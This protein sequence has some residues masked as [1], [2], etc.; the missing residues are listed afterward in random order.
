[1]WT[2][3]DHI[4]KNA[5]GNLMSSQVPDWD[6]FRNILLTEE[7]MPDLDELGEEDMGNALHGLEFTGSLPAWALFE[8]RLDELNGNMDGEFDQSIGE[9]LEQIPATSWGSGAWDQ[10]SARLDDLNAEMD[11]EFDQTIEDAMVNIPEASWKEQH[12]QMLSTRLDRLNDKPR[13]LMMKVIEAAAILLLLIQLSNL[14]TGYQQNKGTNNNLTT[15]LDRILDSADRPASEDNND[16]VVPP[17]SLPSES[18]GNINENSSGDLDPGRSDIKSSINSDRYEGSL[19][20]ESPSTHVDRSS[21]NQGGRTAGNPGDERISEP[22]DISVVNQLPP[23]QPVHIPYD[24]IQELVDQPDV[25]PNAQKDNSRVAPHLASDPQLIDYTLDPSEFQKSSPKLG[26]RDISLLSTSS[27]DSILRTIPTL[28]VIRPRIHSSMEVGMLADATN[29]EIEDYYS[30]S[31]AYD[32]RTLNAGGYFRYKIQYQNIFGSLGADYLNMRY[33]GVTSDNKLSMI[34]L[35][36]E[37]GYNVV[38]LP[39]F[40]MYFSGGVA[41]RFVP[42][43]NYSPETFNQASPY[44][45]KSNKPSFGL[46]NNGPFEINSYLSGR[47]S[48]GL[49]INVN[50]KTSINLRFSHDIWLKGQGIGY[51]HDK[52]RSSHLAIGTNFHL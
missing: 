24:Y 37:L 6:V 42:L 9:A 27:T 35:P 2:R 43:A 4:V 52:F 50:K 36:I 3:F 49:D 8:S 17:N 25:L 1:M 48:M 41:G 16:L 51:N 19:A 26:V 10:M 32:E 38:N 5:L 39:S 23:D 29:V 45:S 12:W 18:A 34:S 13:L 31:G 44:T 20:T 11:A 15:Y 14:Y 7:S 28:Q 40:R 21:D 33:D 47:L 22:G 30:L 46:L